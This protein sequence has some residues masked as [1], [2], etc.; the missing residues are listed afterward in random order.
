MLDICHSSALLEYMKLE[1]ISPQYSGKIFQNKFIVLLLIGNK[2][3]FGS[4][5]G[6]KEKQMLGEDYYRT[7]VRL[8]VGH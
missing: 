3:I 8:V 6:P 4:E 2:R 7:G 1:T 5:A